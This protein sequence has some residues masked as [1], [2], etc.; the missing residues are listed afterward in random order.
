MEAQSK[1]LRQSNRH[2][3]MEIFYSEQSDYKPYTALDK[4]GQWLR[5]RSDS[6]N[7]KK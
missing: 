6:M 4:K 5:E 7:A 3:E 2:K 1:E